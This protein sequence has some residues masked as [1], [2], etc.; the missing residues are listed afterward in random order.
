MI[1]FIIGILKRIFM[2]PETTNK[3][4]EDTNINQKKIIARTETDLGIPTIVSGFNTYV[5][6]QDID[7]QKSGTNNYT[8]DTF[9]DFHYTIDTFQVRPTNYC[10]L[11]T[12][13][14]KM[15]VEYS[16]T[17]QSFV[18]PNGNFVQLIYS[19]GTGE[20]PTSVNF[21]SFGLLYST[22]VTE[23]LLW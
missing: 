12:S 7:Y 20:V 23:D 19:L 11:N 18:N 6:T 3:V 1:D 5:A 13:T 2:N 17:M 8:Y 4:T 16:V 21:K 10:Q 14:G 22:S 15:T 9:L